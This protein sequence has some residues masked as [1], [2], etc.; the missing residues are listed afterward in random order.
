M[1][2]DYGNR[3]YQD[4]YQ[5]TNEFIFYHN[6]FT[7]KGFNFNEMFYVNIPNAVFGVIPRK[8]H[9]YYAPTL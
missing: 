8:F 9:S 2:I 1:D 4:V 5:C 3:S 6:A 7:W